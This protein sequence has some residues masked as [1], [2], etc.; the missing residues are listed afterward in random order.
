MDLSQTWLKK[1]AHCYLGQMGHLF[2][3][4]YLGKKNEKLRVGRKRVSRLNT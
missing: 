4:T 1:E 3:L 2:I